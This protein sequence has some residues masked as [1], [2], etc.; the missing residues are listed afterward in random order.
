MLLIL[1][2]HLF[3]FELC[4]RVNLLHVEIGWHRHRLLLEVFLSVFRVKR[5]VNDLDVDLDTHGLLFE[6]GESEAPI[7]PFD[8]N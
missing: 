2:V 8:L 4:H 6:I 1:N 3:N 5:T 7:R